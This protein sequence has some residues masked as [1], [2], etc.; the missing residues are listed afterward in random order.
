M[1]SDVGFLVATYMA[2]PPV[3]RIVYRSHIQI[4]EYCLAGWVV[5]PPSK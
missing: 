3:S 1:E 2:E 5:K 4:N